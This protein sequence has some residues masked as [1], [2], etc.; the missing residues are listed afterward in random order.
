ML[1]EK[2]RANKAPKID[3]FADSIADV[4]GG[5]SPPGHPQLHEG[6]SDG[7]VLEGDGSPSPKVGNGN[8]RVVPPGT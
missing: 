5:A 7:G 1:K 8:G 3:E 2:L 4:L 6:G